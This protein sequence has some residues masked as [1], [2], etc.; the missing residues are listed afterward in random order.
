VY[1]CSE[2]TPE[3]ISSEMTTFGVDVEGLGA[4]GDLKIRKY[5]EVYIVEGKVDP[6]K[7]VRDFASAAS[8]YIGRGRVGIRAGAVMSCFF[9]Q[10][11]VD[12]LIRY[13]RA[14]HQT[15]AFPGKGI[16]AYN[17][18]E[19]RDAGNVGLLWPLIR[20]HGLVIMTG[21]TGGFALEEER[22]TEEDVKVVAAVVLG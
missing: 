10:D 9:R 20:A 6:G 21:P 11:K 3:A 14:L 17:L 5:D 19:M 22:V 1:V 4:A 7:I 15:F 2:E 12:E 8:D 13:E 16:C 18:L